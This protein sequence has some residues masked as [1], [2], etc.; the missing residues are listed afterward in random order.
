MGKI[1]VIGSQKGGVGKTTTTLNLAY[2]LKEMGKKVLTV[3]FDSQA[4][5][6]TCYG[7]EDTRAL[8][9]FFSGASSVEEKMSL[10]ALA[11]LIIPSP[12]AIISSSIC[13]NSLILLILF[14]SI[15]CILLS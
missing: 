9:S 11:A 13:D 6:T 4:N 3:D 14:S 15:F 8:G 10:I 2:S 1:M 7:V 5:L 12:Q